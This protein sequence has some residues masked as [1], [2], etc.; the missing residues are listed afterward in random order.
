MDHPSDRRSHRRVPFNC[1][2]EIVHGEDYLPACP[3][4]DISEGGLRLATELPETFEASEVKLLIAML[5]DD[6]LHGS[7]VKG[8][9]A[10]RQTESTGIRFMGLSSETQSLLRQY[11]EEQDGANGQKTRAN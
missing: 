4:L 10:W 5:H 6:D 11:V 9:V 7:L 3:S 1:P 8:E 2:V